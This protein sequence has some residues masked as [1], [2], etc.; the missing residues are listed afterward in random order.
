MNRFIALLYGLASYAIFFIT[1]LYAL[2]FV[3]GLVVPK[4]IDTGA[5]TP[6]TEALVANVLLTAFAR[7]NFQPEAWPKAIALMTV[8]FGTGQ[9]LGPIAIGAITDAMGNLSYALS[10]SAA[11]L[12]AGVAACLAYAAFRRDPTP[13]KRAAEFCPTQAGW[14]I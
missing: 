3:E 10:V 8:S 12:L 4:T 13:E 6:V 9:T 5:N 11:V 2:G 14:R 1:F 7:L